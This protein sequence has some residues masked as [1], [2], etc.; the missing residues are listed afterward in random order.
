MEN[1]KIGLKKARSIA[2][3]EEMAGSEDSRRVRDP[4]S[5]SL[6]CVMKGVQERGLR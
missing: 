3:S 1:R 6:L 2:I 5:F 4:G